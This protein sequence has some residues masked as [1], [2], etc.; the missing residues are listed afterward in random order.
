MLDKNMPPYSFSLPVLAVYSRATKNPLYPL[1]LNICT[2]EPYTLKNYLVPKP[3][4]L[5]HWCSLLMTPLPR[6]FQVLNS[7][8]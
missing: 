5:P 8:L 1:P 3:P 6:Q 7:P 2:Q 4:E